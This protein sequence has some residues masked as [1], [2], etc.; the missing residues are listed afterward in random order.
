MSVTG[1]MR[2]CWVLHQPVCQHLHAVQMQDRAL[3]M[4]L[5]RATRSPK[6]N[7]KRKT[8]PEHAPHI[9]D[10]VLL[11][12]CHCCTKARCGELVCG[13]GDC[14]G[15]YIACVFI[16][17]DAPHDP[18]HAC[19]EGPSSPEQA[20]RGR[21]KDHGHRIVNRVVDTTVLVAGENAG[22]GAGCLVQKHQALAGSAENV[23]VG[24]CN[25]DISRR[26]WVRPIATARN[27]QLGQHG[28]LLAA[29]FGI[30]GGEH[31]EAI[32]YFKAWMHKVTT[33]YIGIT[34]RTTGKN[35][36]EKETHQ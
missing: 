33:L 24:A 34:D 18:A 17:V 9:D 19:T 8:D 23:Q 15:G 27:Q 36:G 3:Q 35:N 5:V 14:G 1:N 31:G 26:V 32:S 7:Y 28:C 10:M 29:C 20:R 2:R 16:V 12:C 30:F 13:N 6:A 22:G 21:W 25:L 4:P 11:A